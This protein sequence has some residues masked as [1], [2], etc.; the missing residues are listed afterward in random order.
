MG[1][2][3]SLLIKFII[4]AAIVFVS[5]WGIGA[6][7]SESRPQEGDQKHADV[8]MI[9]TLKSFG[10]LERPGVEFLHDDHVKALEKK[11]KDCTACHL[12][13]KDRLSLKFLRLKDDSKK[14]VMDLYHSRCIA[15]HKQTVSAGEKA[16]PITCGDCHKEKP[17]VLSVRQ[18]MG[19]INP[20]ISATPELLRISAS[21]ATMNMMKKQ[22][23]Y[24]TPRK[25]KVPAVTAT[26]KSRRKTVFPIE[27]LLTW[28]A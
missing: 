5:T 19:W 2:V 17:G 6:Y 1:K 22:K 20:F 16:G 9:D 25:K 27:W 7:G 28:P 12:S 4:P 8:I 18:P 13:E 21:F 10:K 15:C 26:R 3:R 11:K 23:S 24:F 14:Q